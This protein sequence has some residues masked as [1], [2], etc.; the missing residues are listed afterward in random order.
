MNKKDL[1]YKIKAMLD[2]Y[3]SL[4]DHVMME[5]VNGYDLR[6]ILWMLYEILED[7]SD[8]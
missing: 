6:A 4:P 5:P 3:E 8:E 1:Q 7:E 2:R